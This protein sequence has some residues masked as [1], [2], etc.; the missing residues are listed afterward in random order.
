VRILK[1]LAFAVFVS[2]D[3]KRVIWAQKTE[4]TRAFVTAHSKGFTAFPAM[5]RKAGP[6]AS[7]GMT[8]WGSRPVL[9]QGRNEKLHKGIMLKV[10]RFVNINF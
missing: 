4:K 10:Y 3:S 7:L 6:S 8:F 9:H 1:G 5:R 2:A